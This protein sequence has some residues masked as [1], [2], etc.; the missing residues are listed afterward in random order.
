MHIGMTVMLNC[1]HYRGN[2]NTLWQY[3]STLVFTTLAG[4]ASFLDI[5]AISMFVQVEGDPHNVCNF[6]WQKYL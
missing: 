1:I 2:V 5:L 3:I 4:H 6:F